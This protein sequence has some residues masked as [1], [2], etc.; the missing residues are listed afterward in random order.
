MTA[1]RSCNRLIV[2]GLLFA[3]WAFLK[4]GPNCLRRSP[5]LWLGVVPQSPSSSGTFIPNLL[6]GVHVAYV[7]RCRE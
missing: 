7:N 2:G 4:P 3:M 1:V 5:T 6:G